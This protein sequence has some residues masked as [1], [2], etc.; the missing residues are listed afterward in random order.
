MGR[1]TCRLCQLAL[2][3]QLTKAEAERET[4]SRWR[5]LPAMDRR[6]YKQAM[7]FAAKLSAELVF[8]TLGTRDRIILAWL[9]RDLLRSGN[10]WA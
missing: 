7:A 1:P 4:L 6:T 5:A 8:P 10:S 9:A 2:K 3:A